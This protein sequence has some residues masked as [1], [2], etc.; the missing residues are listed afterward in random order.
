MGSF[1][2]CTW[3]SIFIQR[4]VAVAASGN[5]QVLIKSTGNVGWFFLS[6]LFSTPTLLCWSLVYLK[7]QLFPDNK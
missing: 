3:L 4:T 7:Q 5:D 2:C 1:S 6:Y